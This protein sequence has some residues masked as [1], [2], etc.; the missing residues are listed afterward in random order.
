MAT[1]FMFNT[2]RFTNRLK[3]AGISSKHA[4]AAVE[5]LSEVFETNTGSLATKE[6][7]VA[8]EERVDNKFELLRK[9]IGSMEGR[10]EGKVQT[11]EERIN[12]K[13]VIMEQRLTSTLT[14]NMLIMISTAGTALGILQ[15][16]HWL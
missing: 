6:D 8:L 10:I 14:R 15:H 2:L 12:S 16:L 4:E 13:L 1:A 11:L 9:D 7:V 3:K 5:A